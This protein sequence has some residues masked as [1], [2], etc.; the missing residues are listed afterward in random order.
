[1]IYRV[2]WYFIDPINQRGQTSYSPTVYFDRWKGDGNCTISSTGISFTSNFYQVLEAERAKYLLGKIITLSVLLGN[3]I[4]YSTTMK[5]P[6]EI[7]SSTQ[8]YMGANGL[9]IAIYSNN[10]NMQI[11]RSGPKDNVMAVKLELGSQQTL[12]HQDSDGNW[13]LNDAPPN[14]QQELAKCQKYYFDAGYLTGMTGVTSA[15]G[16][17]FTALIPTPVTMRANPSLNV[18]NITARYNG[19]D[20]TG[21]IVNS[22]GIVLGGG[23][24]ITVNLPSSTTISRQVIGY[25]TD[26][27]GIQ[28]SAEI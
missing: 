18:S 7:P 9:G 21:T 2:N 1:M 12:A 25:F 27:K 28:F 20:Y 23:I 3:N 6:D 15:G 11:F 17:Y 4:F 19:N 14:Y 24:R 22:T 13:I 10:G 16:A 8:T 26:E 5:V